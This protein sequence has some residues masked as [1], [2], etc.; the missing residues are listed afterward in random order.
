MTRHIVTDVVKLDTQAHRV[1]LNHVKC[2]L[3]SVSR[4]I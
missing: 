4:R 3:E 2:V 1:G